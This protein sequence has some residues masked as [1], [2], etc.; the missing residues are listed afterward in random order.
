[1]DRDRVDGW[2][3]ELHDEAGSGLLRWRG[4]L[5]LADERCRWLGH[6]VRSSMAFD[7]GPAIDADETSRLELVGRVPDAV[8]V[9]AGLQS[10]RR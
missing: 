6:G 5:A 8:T 10:C 4:D 1:M 3:A 2:L 7:D 9:A